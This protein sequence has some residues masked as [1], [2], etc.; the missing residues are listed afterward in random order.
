VKKPIF[1]ILL[2]LLVSCYLTADWFSLGGFEGEEPE[3]RV[4]EDGGSII[5]LEFILKGYDIEPV[6]INGDN[7]S[8]VTLPGQITFL[9]KGM[10]ELPTIC[11]SVIIPN[12]AAMGYRI[13]DVEYERQSINTVAPSKG[14]L[15]RGVN[16]EDVPYTFD[17]FYETSSW[18]PYNTVELGEPFIL[19]DYRGISIRINPFRY[20]PKSNQLEIVKRVIVEI[21][22]SGQGVINTIGNSR[23]TIAREF[24]NIYENIFLNFGARG[25]PDSISE[26]A[27]RMVI[28]CGDSYMSNMEDFVSWKRQKGI[29]TKIV[30]VSSIGNNETDIQNFIIDEYNTDDLVWVLLVGDG[31]EV[32]PAT[33]TVGSAV[34][35]DAD[36]VYATVEGSDYYPDLFISRFS[37]RNGSSTD[38]DKQVSRSIGYEKTPQTGADWYHIGLGIASAQEGDS[39]IPDSS[40]CNWLRDSLLTY[41][42]IKVNKSYDYWGTTEMIKG[43]IE[44]GVGIVNYIGHGGTNGWQNGGGFDISD[45]TNLNNP[46]KLPFVISVAC[47]VG[48]FNGSDCYCEASVTAGT[49]N[50]PDG[51]V[52][53]WGSTTSQ[54]WVPPCMGQEGAVNILT[55]N[56][57]NTAG[58]IFFNGACYMIDAYGGA[59][60]AVDMAQTWTIFG[61]ASI[62]LRTDTPQSMTVIHDDI[63]YIGNNTFDIQVVGVEDAL[64]AIYR[65][66]TLFGASYTDVSGMATIDIDPPLTV[67]GD[68]ILTVTAYN[69]IPYITTIAV[70]AASGPYITFLKG[71]IDDS[72]GGN[73]NGRIN[74]GETINL[75]SWVKNV[76]IESAN[77]VYAYLSDSDPFVTVSID[78]TWFGDI[79]AEDSAEGT[80]DYV[81]SICDNCPDGYL[82]D[83]DFQVQDE[84]DSTWNDKPVFTVYAPI[85]TLSKFVINPDSNR[86]LD[87]GETTDIFIT[88]D[89]GGGMDAPLVSGYLF[90]N[91]SY[92]DVPDANGSF[93]DIPSGGSGSNSNDP[94]RVHA[95][96]ET[97]GGKSVTFMLEVTSGVYVDT[98]QFKTFVGAKHYLIWDSDINH[99]S[100]PVLNESLQ[101]CGFEGDYSTTLAIDELDK[102]LSVF[103][104]TG[105]F[106]TNYT[107]GNGSVE[108]I[109]L[110]DYVSRGG[111]LYLEGGDVWYYDPQHGG[112]DF[113]PLFGIDAT[114]DGMGDVTTVQGQGGTFT[115]DMSFSY[116]GE[117]NYIDHIS[118]TGGG[119]LIFENYSPSYDCG[120]ANDAGTYRTVGVSFE[121]GGLVDTTSPSTK[122]ILADSIMHFFGVFVE[123]VDEDTNASM[124]PRVYGLHQ[125]YPNPCYNHT[126]VKYQIPRKGNVSLHIYDV[127][128]RLLDILIN[129]EVE[130]GYH[131]M[132]LDTKGYASGVYFYRLTAGGK[133]FTRKMTVVK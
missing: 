62:Q 53:H 41:H 117:N 87:P 126:G 132:K 91:N 105:I 110:E 39:T 129:R 94:F 92:V 89:N 82:L 25:Y 57:K 18:W 90:E 59:S 128:G 121:F 116:N 100:G 64:C 60:E 49:V 63:I 45:V 67:G 115:A 83:F 23:G 66:D 2:S 61:D 16:P 7:Y 19:R 86:R 32:V 124:L 72:V 36:P 77:G 56:E 108:A 27:G 93:G 84:N 78:S 17:E 85:L 5:R 98:L 122:D 113:G 69:K 119:F 6:E 107:I 125:N 127:S 133:T 103:V 37:S 10:P 31:N 44:E 42:Y 120:V 114:T 26:Y 109:A 65:N 75:T 111:R 43:F 123:E 52:V 24:Y 99:S 112:Y 14:N 50:E 40:R 76:G 13:V 104:C 11:R 46:W 101:N 131:S 20:N 3:I 51:Y 38:I 58:G 1:T 79:P 118:P 29:E 130:A 34:G 97:P 30:A 47:L 102:Y 12:D 106:D 68:V 81:F 73:G 96:A 8:R 35:D 54:H 70:Q 71:I 95:D 33:G 74:P 22:S 4:I 55:H 15:S 9:E 28:I 21:Y 88:L 48:N 80:I